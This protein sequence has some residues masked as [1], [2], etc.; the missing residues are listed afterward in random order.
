MH[1]S[2]MWLSWGHRSE[3]VV[4]VARYK[5]P[6]ALAG[7]WQISL[8]TKLA[9]PRPT[10]SAMRLLPKQIG[11]RVGRALLSVNILPALADKIGNKIK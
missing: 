6:S 9:E 1:K 4:K 10:W 5:N 2:M 11:F 7:C 3:V 8:T